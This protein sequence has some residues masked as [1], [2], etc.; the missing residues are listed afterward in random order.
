M[1]GRRY[2]IGMGILVGLV[3]AL[4]GLALGAIAGLFDG[5]LT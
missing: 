4:V 5:W 3:I 2:P 1:S